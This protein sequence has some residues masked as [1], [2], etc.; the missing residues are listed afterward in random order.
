[1]LGLDMANIGARQMASWSKK[2]ED[3][4]YV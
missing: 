2:E 3:S 4:V 1:M